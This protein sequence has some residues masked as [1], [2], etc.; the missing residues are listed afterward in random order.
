MILW[1]AVDQDLEKLDPFEIGQGVQGGFFEEGKV[2]LYEIMAKGVEGMDIDFICVGAD[3]GKEAA[4]HGDCSGIGIGEAEDIRGE[5]IRLQQYLPDAGCQDLGFTGARAGDDHDG[6][7][8]RI[9][10][11]AL[12]FIQFPVFFPEMLLE[13]LPV[14][15][16]SPKISLPWIVPIAEISDL[17][18]GLWVWAI[19]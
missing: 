1:E 5:Y 18:V 14:D 13:F 6:T 8:R 17:A 15:G 2:L 10:G 12:F 4:A 11:Q 19:F 9:Y 16:H 7:F 3:K